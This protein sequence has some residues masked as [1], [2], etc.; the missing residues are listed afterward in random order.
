MAQKIGQNYRTGNKGHA[1]RV[2]EAR[3]R[4]SWY[5]IAEVFPDRL[6][7]HGGL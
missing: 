5:A 4:R 6:D 7:G 2:G 1:G 3:K